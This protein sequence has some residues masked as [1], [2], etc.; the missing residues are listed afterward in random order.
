MDNWGK[1]IFNYAEDSL[2]ITRRLRHNLNYC[3]RTVNANKNKV[4]MNTLERFNMRPNCS[5]FIAASLDGFIARSDGSLDWL[6][7]ANL[8][9]PAGEDC[10][11]KVFMETI[12]AIVMGRNTFEKVLSLGI[13]W[14][15]ADK[16]VIVLSHRPLN[17]PEN[18]QHIVSQYTGTPEAIVT[19]LESRNLRRL[20]IDGGA[21]IQQFLA[22]GLISE[23]TLT[24]IP[25]LLG[26]GIRLFGDLKN[27]ITLKLEKNKAYDCGYTQ[28]KYS[29][30]N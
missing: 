2:I 16:Q 3:D 29:V 12:D 10:G 11:Y 26:T 14:P 28:V 21:T 1:M 4:F 27:D 22:A 6:D 9:V 18:I 19:M 15:Y 24:V 25:V 23:I 30:P 5:V 7:N 8:L 13:H 17:I 20:Y